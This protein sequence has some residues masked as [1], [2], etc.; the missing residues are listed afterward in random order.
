MQSSQ[1]DQFWVI[2][3]E[4]IRDT[5]S[6]DWHMVDVQLVV[7]TLSY[8]FFII[9]VKRLF[10]HFIIRFTFPLSLLLTFPG[11]KR[12]RPENKN[13]FL[14]EM[15]DGCDLTDSLLSIGICVRGTGCLDHRQSQVDCVF[16]KV[17]S[18]DS[19]SVVAMPCKA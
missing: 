16:F 1:A 5:S 17:I 2:K 13:A 4:E 9:S 19:H 6:G 7:M 15:K 8:D 14:K 18:A 11:L 3:L 10:I 12:K